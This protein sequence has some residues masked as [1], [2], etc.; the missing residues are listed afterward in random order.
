MKHISKYPA[1]AIDRYVVVTD[2]AP[3]CVRALALRTGRVAELRKIA[4]GDFPKSGIMRTDL[5]TIKCAETELP[6]AIKLEQAARKVADEAQRVAAS[7]NGFV[8]TEAEVELAEAARPNGQDHVSVRSEKAAVYAEIERI[9]KAPEPAARARIGAWIDR[10]RRD[11]EVQIE[12][13]IGR[14]PHFLNTDPELGIMNA[15]LTV[16]VSRDAMIGELASRIDAQADAVM[17]PSE[18]PA[19]IAALEARL[20]QL[21]ALETH[22]VFAAIANGQ[23]D[24]SF[25]PLTPAPVILGVRLVGQA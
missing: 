12:Q 17:A 15:L 8:D 2:H 18:R 3:A 20:M 19:K 10:G 1:S 11:A 7:V 4:G 24:V 25:D 21:Q 5:A 16:L 6:E 14:H 22:F 9:R 13:L 23:T